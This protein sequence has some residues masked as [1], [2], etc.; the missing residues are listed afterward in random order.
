MYPA[1]S[2]LVFEETASRFSLFANIEHMN[3]GG[4]WVQREIS[5]SYNPQTFVRDE[6]KHDYIVLSTRGMI[7]LPFNPGT[8]E[9]WIG[10]EL[11]FAPTAP[12][13]RDAGFMVDES[14]TILEKS[15][16]AW[17][18][19]AYANDLFTGHRIGIL[20]G[21]TEPNW[22]VSSSFRP[23]VTMSEIRY[24]YTFSSRL[25]YEMRFRIQSDLF[26]PDDS[27]FTRRDRDFYARF[28]YRF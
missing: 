18:V 23:N 4:R 1:R 3:T 21:Q 12:L 19:S 10:G 22:L 20:Y 8:G 14:R 11:G 2:P 13:P 27:G 28:T 15:S 7:R 9:F 6:V 5:V 17:Q 24:R 25:N 16:A 26:K